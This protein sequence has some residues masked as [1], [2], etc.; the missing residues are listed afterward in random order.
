MGHVAQSPREGG[1]GPMS[2]IFLRIGSNAEKRYVERVGTLFSGLVVR[3]NLFEA[4]PGMVASL[5]CRLAGLQEPRG[6]IIDPVTYVFGTDPA[7]PGNVRSWQKVSEEKATAKLAADLR[8]PESEVSE[9]WIRPV[10]VPRLPEDEHRREVLSIKRSFRSLADKTLGRMA[11]VAGLRPLAPT[12]LRQPE[13]QDELV[14]GAITYQHE[15][16][17]SRFAHRRYGQL[18]AA[19]PPPMYTLCPYFPV[20]DPGSLGIMASIW[21]RFAEQHQGETGMAVLQ[22][23]PAYLERERQAIVEALDRLPIRAV[24]LWIDNFEEERA[25][26][27]VLNGYV[28][29][30]HEL[31]LAG[32]TVV[33]LFGGGLSNLLYPFGL[34]GIINNPGY[35]DSKPI[36]PVSGG[37]PAAKYYLPSTHKRETVEDAHYYLRRAGLGRSSEEFRRDVCACP[38]CRD[39]IRRGAADLIRYFGEVGEAD[40]R[41]IYHPTPRAIERCR[42]H[43]LLSRLIEFRWSRSASREELRERLQRD[44]NRWR[45]IPRAGEHLPRWLAALG[46]A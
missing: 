32:K 39:A 34:A 5:I 29:L 7:L 1:A 17:G 3:A 14:A 21:S 19:I 45:E 6:Y 9:E 23:T 30:V 15:A 12:D 41:R 25:D 11:S 28:R 16:V 2:M 24:G 18:A 31:S 44:S 35:G 10:Q 38:I 13:V 42:F 36:V 33:N 22:C 43:F 20:Q 26:V 8:V 40:E 27:G 37:R 46:I 4:S